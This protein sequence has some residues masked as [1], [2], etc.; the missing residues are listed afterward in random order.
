MHRQASDVTEETFGGH[1]ATAEC[2]WVEECPNPQE[3]VMSLSEAN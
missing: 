1:R 3:I 2:C